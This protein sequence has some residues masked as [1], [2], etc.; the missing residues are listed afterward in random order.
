MLR[1]LDVGLLEDDL[2]LL[3]GDLGAPQ[4]PV[5]RVEG[6]GPGFGE[7]A[8][9]RESGRAIAPSGR[10]LLALSDGLEPSA[11][12]SSLACRAVR[13]A[14]RFPLRLVSLIQ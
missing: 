7:I 9:N 6:V 13:G 2:A 11:A 10:S 14:N 4:L 3:V 5:D 8:G 1:H 12:T